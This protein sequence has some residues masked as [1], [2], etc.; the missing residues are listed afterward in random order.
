MVELRAGQNPRA[1]ADRRFDALLAATVNKLRWRDKT[2][3]A[4]KGKL[5]QERIVG[6]FQGNLQ[7]VIAKG[8][9]VGYLIG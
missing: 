8:F 6:A 9:D 2:K 3:R 5:L 4:G 1:G 7:L